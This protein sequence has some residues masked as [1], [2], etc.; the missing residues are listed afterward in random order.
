MKHSNAKTRVMLLASVASMI[1]QFNMSNVY[2]LLEM[3]VQVHVACN[4]R[5]GNTCD[6]DRLKKLK[7]KLSQLQVVWHQWDCPR[8]ILPGLGAR[9]FAKAYVQ[10]VRWFEQYSFAWIHCQSPV[11]GVLARVAAIRCGIPVIYTAH[12]FHFYQG[13]PLKNWLFY[14]SAEKLLSYWTDVLITVN[15]EDY[16]FAKRNLNARHIYYI[17]GVGVADGK[18]KSGKEADMRR[19]CRG[20]YRI[21]QDA[22]LILSVG[23]LS[24]RKNHQAVLTVLAKI[25]KKE[26][27]YLV[28][29]QGAC[30]KKLVRQAQKLGIAGQVRFVGYQ[31]HMAPFYAAAD[32]FVFPS[33]QEGMPV[34]L[35]EAMAA[36]L[37]CVVSDIRGNRELIDKNGGVIF[38]PGG[39]QQLLD[40]L[41]LLQDR[42]LRQKYGKYNKEKIQAYSIE[43]VKKRM[44]RIYQRIDTEKLWRK[45]GNAQPKVSVIMPVYNMAHGQALQQAVASIQ[46]QD[47]DDWELIIC[48]DGSTDHTWKLL[49]K[50]AVRD[51]RIC[52]IH[53]TRNRKAGY[54]RNLCI[55]KAR[56]RYIAMMDADDRSAPGRLKVQYEYLEKH[57]ELD[58]AGCR[59]EFFISSI[60]DDKQCYPYCRLPQP[61]D[62]LF[63][64]PYVH[65]SVMFRKT[66]LEQVGGYDSSRFAV[67]AEDY[68]LLLRMYAAGLRGGN[69]NEVLYY[70]RRDAQQYKRRKYRYRF[71]EAFIK[72]R[73]F[74]K[75]RIMPKGAVYAL[76]PLLVGLFPV[77]LTVAMQ[78]YYYRKKC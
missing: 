17:P 50:M 33:L 16:S 54:A 22:C 35:M 45:N 29:G 48:D 77:R 32:L 15:R 12:G 46:R 47:F 57:K 9:S 26:I 5:Q 56:G 66:A 11:G 39:E 21:P 43:T 31:E 19:E 24:K 60:G 53:S 64:L 23:E 3:G 6:A 61:E 30:R 75:L 62:F 37:A 70:I 65:A 8:T 27:F 73:G 67:R 7:E 78:R 49:Q 63:S 14:Y 59:G 68:D 1:D 69:I 34:A 18:E 52:L 51:S 44:N 40:G 38:A 13:A 55:Q 4:F 58:F 41:L 36:G 25:D 42:K 71:H 74:Y 20:R 2:L 28:C 76:K 72:Y 10:L